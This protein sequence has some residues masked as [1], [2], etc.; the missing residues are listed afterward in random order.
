MESIHPRVRLP[1]RGSR[2]N[3][4]HLLGTVMQHANHGICAAQL[5]PVF[6]PI[7]RTRTTSQRF[8]THR[9]LYL[10]RSSLERGALMS[11]RRTLEGAEKWA[12]RL[13]RRLEDTSLEYFMVSKRGYVRKL[14]THKGKEDERERRAWPISPSCSGLTPVSVRVH[15]RMHAHTCAHGHEEGYTGTG[16]L[17]E[18]RLGCIVGE[19]WPIGEPFQVALCGTYCNVAPGSHTE[20]MA[21]T[22][23]MG[24]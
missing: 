19:Q 9:V 22:F 5:P 12:L 20:C 6:R 3:S 11:L 8:V 14:A 16:S 2:P 17:G 15:T 18:Q 21:R 13:L 24:S 1:S 10:V 7:Q 23:C 4:R